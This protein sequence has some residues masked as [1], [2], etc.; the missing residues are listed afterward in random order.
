MSGSVD[1][2]N[3]ANHPVVNVSCQDAQAFC[4]WAGVQLPSEAEWEKAARGAD[5]RIYPW[6]D[7]PPD[8][9]LCNFGMNVK[10]TTPVGQYPAGTSPY[11]LFDMSGN[12]WEWTRSLWG[13]KLY[14]WDFAYPYRPNDGRED[15]SAPDDVRRVLRGGSWY[16][17][18]V[19]ARCAARSVDGPRI[20]NRGVGFRLVAP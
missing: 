3:K 13:K 6:G 19:D 7:A 2:K 20:L 9:N 17:S 14:Y 4:R 15:L 18:A 10:D 11:G 1:V 16:N 5:G 8:K 12:V